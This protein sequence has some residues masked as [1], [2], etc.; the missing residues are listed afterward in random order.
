MSFR[1]N[2]AI[3]STLKRASSICYAKKMKDDT[4]S[5]LIGYMLKSLAVLVTSLAGYLI[6]DTEELILP[7]KLTMTV[8]GAVCGLLGVWAWWSYLMHRELSKEEKVRR[9]R[10]DGRN[11]CDCSETGE[12]MVVSSGATNGR[13]KVMRCPR[14]GEV[15]GRQYDWDNP[16]GHNQSDQVND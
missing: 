2:P 7:A 8:S 3:E 16:A 1:T 11:I 6:A 13:F 15:Q 12:I 10:R 9:A 14:C 4:K 5:Q